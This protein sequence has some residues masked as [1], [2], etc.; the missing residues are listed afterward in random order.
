MTACARGIGRASENLSR[1]YGKHGFFS[2][3]LKPDPQVATVH[4]RCVAHK[5]GET[6]AGKDTIGVETADIGS[7]GMSDSDK[8]LGKLISTLA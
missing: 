2:Q 4:G 3:G 1:F 6:G 5:G 7:L 8:G